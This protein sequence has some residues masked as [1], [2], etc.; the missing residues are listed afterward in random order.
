ML[1]L[2]YLCQEK[3]NQ[4][5]EDTQARVPC[6]TECIAKMRSKFKEL[7]I[8]AWLK[9]MKAVEYYSA[10]EKQN[11]VTGDRRCGPGG[12]MLSKIS[13]PWTFHVCRWKMLM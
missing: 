8:N 7:P 4:H 5:P 3:R 1:Q 10:T 9:K 11:P 13:E 6:S 2:S 12:T